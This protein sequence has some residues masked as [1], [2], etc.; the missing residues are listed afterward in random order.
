MKNTIFVVLSPINT[1]FGVCRRVDRN[2]GG[3]RRSV[4]SGRSVVENDGDVFAQVRLNGSN[5]S[6]SFYL[7]H[8]IGAMVD[9][10]CSRN[11][12]ALDQD[13]T[14]VDIRQK[15]LD[16][17]VDL[18]MHAVFFGFVYIVLG[19]LGILLRNGGRIGL[20]LGFQQTQVRRQNERVAL[21]CAG[22]VGDDNDALPSI[23]HVAC[24][25]D[26]LRNHRLGFFFLSGIARRRWSEK[27]L[28]LGTNG[29]FSLLVPIQ[30]FFGLQDIL[31]F[32]PFVSIGL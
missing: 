8:N 5:G 15:T 29:G 16:E 3:I 28:E 25:A 24:D 21:G 12:L 11:D 7:H 32:F 26:G 9:L 6:V 22:G 2:A 20:H 19:I 4:F 31:G 1:I 14:I 18:A 27:S 10:Q 30:N 13:G 23:Y 17:A